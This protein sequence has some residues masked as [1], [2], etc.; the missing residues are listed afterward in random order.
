[1]LVLQFSCASS[2]HHHGVWLG[3]GTKQCRTAYLTNTVA[4]YLA[5]N[6]CACW[7][8]RR[9]ADPVKEHVR[10]FVGKWRDDPRVSSDASHAE[11]TGEGITPPGC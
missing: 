10:A 8:V 2:V 5:D 4:V 3:G 7:Q 1:M 11:I 6:V 9:K